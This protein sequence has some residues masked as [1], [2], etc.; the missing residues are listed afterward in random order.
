VQHPADA[1]VESVDEAEDKPCRGKEL[2]TADVLGFQ[3]CSVCCFRLGRVLD[4]L[5]ELPYFLPDVLWGG[6]RRQ[7]VIDQRGPVE[8]ARAG[9]MSC[10][11]G[12]EVA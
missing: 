4:N 5:A 2:P 6:E 9:Y 3:A 12:H 11:F 7:E 8:D 10:T 1:F